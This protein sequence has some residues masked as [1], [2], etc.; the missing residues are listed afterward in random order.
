MTVAFW[1]AIH[2]EFLE[3]S[4]YL[5]KK[6]P[7]LKKIVASSLKKKQENILVTQGLSRK[8]TEKRKSKI[9]HENPLE[10]GYNEE[11]EDNFTGLL[12]NK[13]LMKDDDDT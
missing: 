5:V 4:N 3:V 2:L 7:L 1:L 13:N 8:N 10:A 11:D 12:I 9:E 6:I